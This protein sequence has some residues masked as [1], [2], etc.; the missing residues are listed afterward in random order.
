[1]DGQNTIDTFIYII[2]NIIS[3]IF[4]LI[5]VGF[6]AQKKFKM[7]IRTLTRLN[8]YIFVPAVLFIKIYETEVTFRFFFQVLVYVSTI[9]IIMY[10]ISIII[11]KVFKYDKGTSKAFCNSLIFF[12][13]GNYGLPLID[14]VTKGDPIAVT[15]QVFIMLMQNITTN[16][17]GVFQCSSGKQDTKQSIKNMFKMPSIYIILIVI[18]VKLLNVQVPALIMTPLEYVSRGFIAMAL[19]TLGAQL[20]EIKMELRFRDVFVSGFT[21]L[22]LSPILGALVLMLMGIKGILAQALILGVSTP[23]AVNTALIAR[24]FDNEPEYASQIVFVSTILSG[25]TISV[26]IYLTGKLLL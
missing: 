7:D 1:M 4:F 20:S 9:Q 14:L 18:V 2:A 11:S 3:P 6:V 8:I 23:T 10:F 26:I 22:I 13:S 21:R 19:V 24:E 12:N 17:I 15:S 16:T 25:I 5:A